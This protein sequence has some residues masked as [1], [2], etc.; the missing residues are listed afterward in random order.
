M[1]TPDSVLRTLLEAIGEPN[2]VLGIESRL[3]QVKTLSLTLI[4]CLIYLDLCCSKYVYFVVK[5]KPR[6]GD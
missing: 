6:A 4:S 2:A 5:N 1:L 3:V